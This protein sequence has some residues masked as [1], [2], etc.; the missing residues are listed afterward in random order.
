MSSLYAIVDTARDARL[1]GLVMRSRERVCLFA[2]ELQSPLERAAPY[3]VCS[4]P[5]DALFDAWRNHGW[6]R[7]WG[8]WCRSALDLKQ[9]RRHFRQY[10]QA[11]LPDG[12]VVLFRYYDPRVWRTYLPNCNPDELAGWFAGVDEYGVEMPGGLG[13][14]IYRLQNGSLTIAQA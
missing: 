2:G 8:I 1:Y 3:L 5:Y 14:L 10:L 11:V 4:T 12:K 13:T 6:G 9:L 7:S